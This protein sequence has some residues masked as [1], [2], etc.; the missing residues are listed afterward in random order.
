MRPGLDLN[1]TRKG[2][3]N[4]SSANVSSVFSQ[5]TITIIEGRTGSSFT[6]NVFQITP[7]MLVGWFE[8]TFPTNT[9]LAQPYFYS[10]AFGWTTFGIWCTDNY[11]YG[12]LSNRPNKN[13]WMLGGANYPNAYI[14]AKDMSGKKIYARFC[15]MQD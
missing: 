5:R 6:H 10:D 11:E 15:A 8:F 14:S 12:V 3:P 9:Q 7:G 2:A 1:F 4:T 13:V